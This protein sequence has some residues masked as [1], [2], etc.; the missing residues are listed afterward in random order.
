VGKIQRDVCK[1]RAHVVYEWGVWCNIPAVNWYD[2]DDRAAGLLR[3][4]IQQKVLGVYGWD[5]CE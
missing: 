3:E 4:A 5:G 1:G 2:D